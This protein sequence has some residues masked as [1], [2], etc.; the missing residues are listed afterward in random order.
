MY[1]SVFAAVLAV[2]VAFGAVASP[3][4]A[5]GEVNI[6]SE[7]QEVLIRPLLDRFTKTTGI[8]TNVVFM[9]RGTLT[10]LKAEGRNS[11]ADIVL[12]TDAARLIMLDKAGVLQPSESAI[13][14]ANIPA[15]LRHPEG[16][17]YGLT[18]RARPIFYNPAKVKPSELSTYWALSDPKWKGRICIRSSSNVYNLSLLSSMIAHEGPEKTLAWAKGFVKNFA[19]SPKG[20]D[21]DQIRAVASGECDIAI[22]NTYYMGQLTK[23]SRASDRKAAETVKIFWPNQNSTGTHVNISGAAVTRSAPNKANAIKLI[24]FLSG[25]EAQ[26]IYAETVNEYPI[27][28]GVPMS[29]VVAA[30]GEFK[31]DDL[32]LSDLGKYHAQ[33][34]RI[35]DQA[36]WR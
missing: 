15:N 23:S 29:K 25:N 2:P 11:P 5:Q 1:R 36:G 8:K 3:V 12:T 7:R 17:W 6:Y 33:A 20:G 22:A 19:R 14:A 31:A 27:K 24:E 21:R 18:M 13:L 28:P 16:K 9:K 34:V 30:W 26:K 4:L 10:R 32:P 35:A